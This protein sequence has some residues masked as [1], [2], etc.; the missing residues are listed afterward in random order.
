M[1]AG[2]GSQN[3]LIKIRF[4]TQ[5]RAMATRVV[6]ETRMNEKSSRSHLIFSVELIQVRIVIKS[7]SFYCAPRL[8][9]HQSYDPI[10]KH[11]QC[12][13]YSH[14]WTREMTLA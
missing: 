7:D 13:I 2:L 6:G 3:S 11:I 4:I 12:I 9:L 1:R 14:R 10:H 8:G 5:S